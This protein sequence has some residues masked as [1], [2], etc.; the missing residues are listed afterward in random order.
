LRAE[1][2]ALSG[3]PVDTWFISDRS[4]L[5]AI[6]YAK[7]FVGNEAAAEMI[8][9][10][11]WKSLEQTM[12]AG[13][14]VLCEAGCAWLVDDGTRL[15]PKDVADWLRFD[16]VFREVLDTVDMHTLVIP[17]DLAHIQDRVQAVLDALGFPLVK[18]A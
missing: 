12:R 3:N 11:E 15:M 1:E 9:S 17:K 4:G 2:A 13:L 10:A 7:H 6:V 18:Q 5:D 14:V 16:S 8:S